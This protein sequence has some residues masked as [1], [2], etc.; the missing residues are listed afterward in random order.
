M[1]NQF[2]PE[3]QLLYT[4]G[5]QAACA[6]LVALR[7]AMELELIVE[8]YTTLCTAAHDLIVSVGDFCGH[9]PREEV[10]LGIK[11]GS[12]KEIAILSRVGK[13]LAFTITGIDLSGSA[14][15]L[16]LSRRRAQELTLNALL[17]QEIGTILPATVTHME[18]FGAFVDIGCGFVSMVGID[19]ISVSRISH[20]KQR[21]VPGQA[22]Y[23]VLTGV[24]QARQR[25]FLSHKELLGT[26]AENAARFAVGMTVSGY[27]R[28]IQPY[29][30]FI[31][32]T[33]N[34]SGLAERT[35]DL[36]ENDHVSVYI[37]SIQADRM[38]IK[39]MLIDRLSSNPP[40]APLSYRQTAGCLQSWC[41]APLPQCQQQG[42]ATES[43]LCL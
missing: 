21:F 42:L 6:S 43:P 41:Y 30:I 39:L 10:A 31:E 36:S 1:S 4:T 3:G 18:S 27:V 16:L 14:P 13:P 33:P 12:T 8:G 37:K 20:P 35:R 29:G 28:G 23:V 25:V 32:L 15:M 2:L 38:K 11:E 24:D 22:I 17:Q 5:N 7:Q 40:P 34:L 26:W 19:Q 9:M